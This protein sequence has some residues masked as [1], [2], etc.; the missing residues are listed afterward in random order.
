[1]TLNDLARRKKEP[2]PDMQ[3]PDCG[4]LVIEWECYEWGWKCP[5]AKGWRYPCDKGIK[6]HTKEDMYNLLC[7][8]FAGARRLGVVLS[9]LAI[10]R[11]AMVIK[12]STCLT[13]AEAEAAEA[14][15]QNHEWFSG[16][17]YTI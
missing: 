1:M 8:A 3:C 4:R 13:D 6:D 15:Y 11:Q 10:L 14:I 12:G 2:N 7:D 9:R 5:C 17:E 16:S